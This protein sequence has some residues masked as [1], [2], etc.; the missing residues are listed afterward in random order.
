MWDTR[1]LKSLGSVGLIGS[2]CSCQQ[3]SPGKPQE[4]AAGKAAQELPCGSCS[5]T[6]EM[7]LLNLPSR[8]WAIKNK[9]KS[10]LEENGTV[11]FRHSEFGPMFPVPRAWITTKQRN[12][13]VQFLNPDPLLFIPCSGL[14]AW[15]QLLTFP[16]AC[17]AMF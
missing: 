1:S 2:A 7:I 5:G 10:S 11:E 15:V 4:G 16:P 9:H 3:L 14:R 6:A 8:L 12:N 13:L 17:Q